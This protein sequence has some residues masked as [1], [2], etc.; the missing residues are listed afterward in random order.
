MITLDVP[1]SLAALSFSGTNYTLTGG[2]ITLQSSTGTATVTAAGY[3]LAGGGGTQT[4][5]SDLVLNS[6]ATFAPAATAQLTLSGVISGTGSLA[7]T[8]A[9]TLLLS[10]TTN[11]YTGGTCVDAG[12]MIINNSAALLDGSSLVVGR[13]ARSSSIHG[14]GREQRAGSREQD[15]GVAGARAGTLALLLAAL[16]SAV[17]CH[18]FQDADYHATRMPACR[19][20]AKSRLALQRSGAVFVV[21]HFCRKGL[22]CDDHVNALRFSIWRRTVVL[23]GRK[24]L[25]TNV[26]QGQ[27]PPS[28]PS[29][30]SATFDARSLLCPARINC[31]RLVLRPGPG[32]PTRRCRQS[33]IKHFTWPITAALAM[34]LR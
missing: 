29:Y 6:P 31:H 34:A 4:I 26:P 14:S 22:M 21:G 33:L 13:A 32:P 18:R 3:P 23:S 9:G 10:G 7:Q 15:G 12:T 30:P 16:W 17:A 11:S 20:K 5:A 2:T 25:L 27:R 24:D 8:D 28:D 1:V 19:E